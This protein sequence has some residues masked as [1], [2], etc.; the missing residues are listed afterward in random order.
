MTT[1]SSATTSPTNLGTSSASSAALNTSNALNAAAGLTSGT[2]TSQGIGSGLNVSSIVSQLVSAIEAPQQAQITSESQQ[3]ASLVAALGQLQGGMSSL[4]S[5]VQPLE[6]PT[7]LN[8]KTTTVSA[9]TV[10]TATATGAVPTGSYSIGVTQ[11]AQA[12]QLSSAAFS[13][14][15]TASVGTGTLT[16]SSGG[17]SFNVAIDG[18]NNSLSG[19]AAAINNA[20]ANPGISATVLNGSSGAYLL[21]TGTATGAANAV[22][23]SAAGGDGGLSK[24]TY[25]PTTKTG[26]LSV[27]TPAQD[28]ALTI[29]GIAVTSASNTVT[30]AIGG[31]TLNLLQ[32]QTTP[33]TVNISNDTADI[34]TAVN[35]FVTAYN[36]LADTL[37]SLT[38]YTTSTS[39]AGPL[40][41]DAMANNIINQLQVTLSNNVAGVAAPYN[42]LAA[43][44]I[45]MNSSGDLTVDSTKLQAA[46]TANP[47]SVANVIAGTNGIATQLY[48][49]LSGHLGPTGDITSRN[50]SI[51]TQQAAIAAQTSELNARMAIVQ[52]N[53]TQQFTALDT[54]LSQMQTTSSFLTQQL[55]A[56]SSVANTVSSLGSNSSIG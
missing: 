40:E 1:V 54:L 19:I 29:N 32:T 46:L 2:I 8:L 48:N 21:L 31:L 17:T 20:P 35:G 27:I 49:V 53:Y 36:S 9:P 50:A 47:S 12:A 15:A 55:N 3:L 7:K 41:G 13:G 30:T 26:G 24:L 25:D 38:G 10:L 18:T 56:S 42:N 14:G 16:L 5:A 52:A 37:G 51:A 44:G 4:Q 39:T 6:D 43:L 45:T 28:A 23:V 11:L 22:T 34:T 33:F